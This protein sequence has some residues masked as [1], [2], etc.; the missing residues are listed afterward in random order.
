VRIANKL[1][2]K[3]VG[4]IATPGLYGDG[5]SLYLQVGPTGT[6]AWCFRYSRGGK[7][8]QMGLGSVASVT[9][10]QARERA[11]DARKVVQ[12][13]GDPIAERDVAKAAIAVEVEKQATFRQV[14]QKY[15]DTHEAASRNDR[16]CAQWRKTLLTYVY[17]TIGTVPISAVTGEQVLRGRIENVPAPG[18]LKLSRN[19][20]CDSTLLTRQCCAL[21]LYFADENTYNQG[22]E[23]VCHAAA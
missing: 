10:A 11:S 8:H 6:K 18:T 23:L 5:A 9:L 15:I 3:G 20:R 1:T 12:R 2:A 4:A 21:V 16:H 14:A 13:G 17:P 22:G 19:N 7:A